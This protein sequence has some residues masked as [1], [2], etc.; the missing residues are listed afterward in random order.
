MSQEGKIK[1]VIKISDGKDSKLQ[2]KDGKSQS[3]DASTKLVKIRR[4]Q[5]Q[6]V[7]WCDIYIGRACNMGGWNL[8]QSKWHNPF[9]VNKD[10]TLDE[11]FVKYEEYI[12]KRQDLLNCLP[13]LSGKTLG[14]WC[15]PNKCHG[16][17]L[18]KLLHER[19]LK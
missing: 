19:G 17:I 13:E 7:Q 10:G 1:I 5:G 9:K 8:P 14:C 16:D 12:H 3:N 2:D 15:K 18:L 11:V 6:V 4:H